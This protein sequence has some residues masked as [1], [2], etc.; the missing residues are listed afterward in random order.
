M[1]L[2]YRIVSSLPDQDYAIMLRMKKFFG[3]G[4]KTVCGTREKSTKQ[5]NQ[6]R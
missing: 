1:S 6:L 4:L 2:K 3:S 5:Q